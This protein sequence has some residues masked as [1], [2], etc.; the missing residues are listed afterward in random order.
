[1]LVSD[2]CLELIF[3]HST[4]D[5]SSNQSDDTGRENSK[6]VIG[7]KHVTNI[8]GRIPNLIPIC[9]KK[10]YHPMVVNFQRTKII[11]NRTFLSY[12]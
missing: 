2:Y 6:D 3:E 7:L 1:M 12:I 4:L 5:F 8:D 9:F 11:L 10:Y